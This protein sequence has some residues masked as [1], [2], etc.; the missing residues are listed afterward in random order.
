MPFDSQP[1]TSPADDPVI[2]IFDRVLEI[3]GPNGEN[4]MQFSHSRDG[5]F[6]L[7]GAVY[8]ASKHYDAGV[9]Q[10]Q[11]FGDVIER[12]SA[13]IPGNRIEAWNDH[14]TRRFTDIRAAVMRARET[15]ASS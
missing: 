12:L 14:S 6:C 10:R 8:E 11:I 1:A 5:R 13:A 3:F 2:K 15:H 4:W 7:L 9:F